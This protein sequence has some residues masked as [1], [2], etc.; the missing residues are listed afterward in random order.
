MPVP[1]PTPNERKIFFWPYS[2]AAQ[3]TFE[4]RFPL[5]YKRC[6]AFIGIFTGHANGE[7]I[8]F[9]IAARGEVDI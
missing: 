8:G 9:N 5:F 2:H 7:S 6:R 1:F 4:I 3:F